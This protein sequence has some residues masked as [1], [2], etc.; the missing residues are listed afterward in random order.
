MSR[1]PAQTE[2]AVIGSGISGM[3]AAVTLAES[4]VKVIVF[5]KQR[6][7]G[8]TSNFFGGMFAVESAM[9]RERYISYTRDQAFKNIMEY[10]HWRANARLVRAIVDESAETITWLQKQGVVFIDATTNMPDTPR[11]YHIV[12]GEGAEAIKALV[13][14]AKEKGVVLAPGTPVKRILKT[15]DRVTGII[16]EE[17]GDE[18]QVA[19]K[20]I[21]IASG[22]YANNKDWIKKYSGFDLGINL[23][24]IGSVDKMGDGIR[25]A[26]EVGAA[27]EGLGVLEIFRVGPAGPEFPLGGQLEFAAVQP[28][29]WVDQQGE[30]FCDESISFYDTATGNANARYRE[31]YTYSIFDDSIKNRILEKGIE[32]SVGV[33]NFP[34]SRPTNFDGEFEIA[35]QKS[36]N[37]VFAANSLEE[38]AIKIKVNPGILKNTVDEYNKLCEK[39]HDDLFAKDRKYLYPLRG[40]KYYAIKARTVFLGTLGGIK[41]NHRAEV[42]DKKNNAI[43]GLYAAGYDAGGLYGDGYSIRDSS[44]LSSAFAANSGRIAAKNI[45]KLLGR[46]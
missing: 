32:R 43:P 44:G 4:G 19:S 40:P 16:A 22:G 37:D 34:G 1:I 31:G 24:P 10:S 23:I 7:L 20:A 28:D 3:A 45:L 8:G 14:S 2:V 25:M 13:L 35:L 26:L 30:R 9:Q 42:V 33:N 38:L 39:G 15:G 41:I 6:S 36:Q 18:V 5:E 12:K 46:S 17:A 27:D 11:T 21:V 29:L